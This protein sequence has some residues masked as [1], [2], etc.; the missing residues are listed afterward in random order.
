VTTLLLRVEPPA[1]IGEQYVA[2][3]H[4]VEGHHV[5]QPSSEPT[6]YGAGRTFEDAV[7]T[8]VEDYRRETE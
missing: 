4:T 1:E 8:A 6:G 7:T 2:T 5:L 3:L